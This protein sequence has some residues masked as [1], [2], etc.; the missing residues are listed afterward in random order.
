MGAAER[1]QVVA[2]FND[3]SGPVP[4]ETMPELILARAAACPDAIAV[5]YGD[6]R[7][8]YGELAARAGR[9]ARYVGRAGAGPERVVALC[10]DRAEMVTAILG[11]WLAGAAYVPLD[12]G[13]PAARLAHMLASSRAGLLVTSGGLAG[14]LA[15]PVV[16]DLGD[17]R[18]AAE[19]ATVPRTPPRVRAA[20]QQLAYVIYTSG[21]TGVPNG[22]AVA[23]GSLVNLAAGLAPVLGAEPGA[24]VL[25]FASFSFDA[26]VLDV[27]VTLASGGTLAVAT[28]AQRTEPGLLT[29][30]ARRAGVGSASVVPSL[31]EVLD[32]D[33]LPRLARLLT[34]AETLTAR[35]AAAWAPARTL[36][37]TYGPTEA[38]VM[39]T[40]T[41]VDQGAAQAP[42]IGRP[43]VNT[44]MLVL[45]QWLNPVP[46]RVT[47]ELYVAGAGLARGYLGAGADRSPVR[48]L[49]VR[50]GRRADVPD[51][52]PGQVDGGRAA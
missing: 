51:G 45:D 32:P 47:A 14:E 40:T 21:S 6:H 31:L 37:N 44:R 49:P 20:A 12:P 27:A 29:A 36:V 25:Q 22:V 46:A 33:R 16:L 4:A 26:S 1:E 41:V 43:I 35:L 9:L 5:A 50:R 15:G 2:R 42:P 10:L 34:G 23:H 48:G 13:Y 11:V 28:A 24:V 52:R 8:S 39:V 7:V 17:P 38:T 3:T 19:L 18:T 30:M